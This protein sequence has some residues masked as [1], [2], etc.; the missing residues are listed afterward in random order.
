MRDPSLKELWEISNQC[1]IFL[2]QERIT[3]QD[4]VNRLSK[5]DSMTNQSH[6]SL[7]QP[8]SS[9]NRIQD[10]I[11]SSSRNHSIIDQ[12]TA[13]DK[14]VPGH[15]VQE[16]PLDR[17]TIHPGAGFMSL[18]S[19]FRQWFTV[20]DTQ[21]TQA[22][23]HIN[24]T[25]SPRQ[26]IAR[27]SC[28]GEQVSSARRDMAR[29]VRTVMHSEITDQ[30]PPQSGTSINGTKYTSILFDGVMHVLYQSVSTTLTRRSGTASST[31]ATMVTPKTEDCSTSGL[32]SFIHELCGPVS[33]FDENHYRKSA[34]Y[35]RNRSHK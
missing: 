20:P 14:Q 27:S 25:F 9:Q 7:K 3:I 16:I 30:S 29:S 11:G 5:I 19:M 6:K 15:Q 17:Q 33:R 12:S 26:E 32:S 18:P 2:P 13:E 23:T 21:V 24:P 4:I 34:K 31:L 10:T 28:T 1:W 35:F 8:I 22:A